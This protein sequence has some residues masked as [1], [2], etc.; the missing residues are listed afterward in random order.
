MAKFICLTQVNNLGLYS[1]P[2]GVGYQSIKGTPFIVSN[3]DDINY[4]SNKKQFK[5]LGVIDIIT[6]RVETK[7]KQT[8]EPELETFLDNI[9]ELS[10]VSKT[11]ILKAYDT[12]DQVKDDI[13]TD[14]KRF[15]IP[16]NQLEIL[17]I[18]LGLTDLLNEDKEE[19]ENDI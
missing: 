4:F 13:E 6:K 14:K 3:E 5:K 9:T 8:I 11:K 15:N 17:K 2:S 16:L 18:K 10:K 7:V 1:G 19:I 12:I